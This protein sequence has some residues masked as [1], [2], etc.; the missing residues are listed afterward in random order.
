MSTEAG[1]AHLSIVQQHVAQIRQFGFF[2]RAL[3]MQHRLGVG[4]RLVRVIA[5]PFPVEVDR[6]VARVIGRVAL[7]G[8]HAPK[9]LQAR[10]RFQLRPIHREVFVRE[11]PSRPRVGLDRLKERG[12]VVDGIA[13]V[14]HMT[15]ADGRRVVEDAA[16]VRG[17]DAGTNQW[18]RQRHRPGR[19]GADVRR[20]ARCAYLAGGARTH[21]ARPAGSTRRA[22]LA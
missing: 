5:P 20:H 22:G 2:P 1:Q 19:G 18:D 9:A 12:G 8:V 10:P 14:I 6:G 21:L 3:P 7:R 15:R 4:R 16:F 17:Y 13:M 11:Q